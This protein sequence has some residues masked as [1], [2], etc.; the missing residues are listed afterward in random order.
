M[1]IIV[2]ENKIIV[3]RWGKGEKNNGQNESGKENIAER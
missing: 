2:P 3:Q 1:D